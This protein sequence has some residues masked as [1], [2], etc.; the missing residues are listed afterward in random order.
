MHTTL[1]SLLKARPHRVWWAGASV[2]ALLHSATALAQ[3]CPTPTVALCQQMDFL[4]STCGQQSQTKCGDILSAEWKKKLSTFPKRS[5]QLPASM[6]GQVVTTSYLARDPSKDQLSGLED[7][8]AGT[9]LKNQQLYRKQFKNLNEG[10]KLQQEL[11]TKWAGNG[12]AVASCQEYVDEKYND[13]SRF[14]ARV[15]QF[16]TDYLA[17][18]NAA[19]AA[20]GGISDRKLYD[21]SGNT[22]APIWTTQ[23]LEKNAY[24]LFAPGP[25]PDGTTAYVFSDSL[26]KQVSPKGRTWF[27]ATDKW[28]QT[29]A[30]ALANYHV[31]ELNGLQAQQEDFSALLD[32][33]AQAW[34]FYQAELARMKAAD[35]DPK[36]LNQ[37]TAKSLYEMDAAIERGLEDG[38]KQ[39]CLNLAANTKCDW[40]P[41][42][43]KKMLDAAMFPRRQADYQRCLTLT[44]ND[45]GPDSFVRNSDKLGIDGLKGDRTLNV[46]LLDDYLTRYAAQLVGM[47]T[48]VDPSTGLRRAGAERSG[49]SLLGNDTFGLA[50]DYAGGWGLDFGAAP[51]GINSAGPRMCDANLRLYGRFTANAVVFGGRAEVINASALGETETASVHL[52]AN[53]RVLGMD[54]APFPYDQHFPARFNVSAS[55]SRAG[56][57]FSASG[58]YVV[59]FIPVTVTAGLNGAVGLQLGLNGGVA[60]DCVNDTVGVDLNGNVTPFARLD[61]LASV[62]VGLPGIAAAGI[63]GTLNL[64]RADIPLTGQLG[65]Y[66]TS[67]S[68]PTFP[69]MLVLHTGTSMGLNL[70]AL[71][72]RVVVFATLGPYYG[73]L[74]LASWAGLAY[75]TTL[76]NDSFETPLASLR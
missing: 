52:Q 57:I 14:E 11:L 8:F 66:V 6:G 76:F 29:L 72:G 65:L 73:E 24:Y 59:V 37:L 44:A 19:N 27:V 13:Y 51:L 70:E 53:L 43:Y 64:V 58:T 20:E 56:T 30:T 60:R 42:R 40:S 28:H 25:Y 33:R 36:E 21:R 55:P 67:P 47:L 5:S 10:D 69:S 4:Q 12:E 62:T 16:G 50:Y 71:S 38:A 48:P 2:M 45:F 9:V 23:R 17:V 63:M 41:R 32:R 18:F 35:Q 1:A 49:N 54:I 39:G 46:A 31:D 3:T 7:T 68:H 22:L 15:G 75:H 34:S 61:A 26:V 74:E